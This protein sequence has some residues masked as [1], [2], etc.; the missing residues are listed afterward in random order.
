MKIALESVEGIGFAIPIDDAKPIIEQLETEGEVTRPFM[1]ISAVNLSSVP[2]REL[3]ET[4]QL[5]EN[6]ENGIVVAQVEASSPAENAGLQQYDVIT[7]I[8]GTNIS[9]MLE[10]KKHLYNETEVGEQIEVTYY[11]EGQEQT[12]SLTLS[13]QG[14]L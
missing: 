1:G 5:D 3:Q 12:T 2:E 4:L 14:N 8:S 13:E 7:K 10:L 9:S 11:R 6:V